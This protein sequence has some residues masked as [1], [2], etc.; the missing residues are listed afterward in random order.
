MDFSF[1]LVLATTS[2]SEINKLNLTHQTC[3]KQYNYVGEFMHISSPS[4]TKSYLL[5]SIFFMVLKVTK[6]N[7]GGSQ[8]CCHVIVI[9]YLFLMK[10]PLEVL[11][12]FGLF[13]YAYDAYICL[14]RHF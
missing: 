9:K 14:L 13:I 3:E 11:F 8:N 7:E 1:L 10:I 12:L 5:L 2:C 6:E 4:N